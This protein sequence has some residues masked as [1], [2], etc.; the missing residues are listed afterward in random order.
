ITSAARLW[1]P[2]NFTPSRPRNER[3]TATASSGR[4]GWPLASLSLSRRAYLRLLLLLAPRKK[5]LAQA[6]WGDVRGDVLITPWER[7]KSRKQV[8]KKR[9][10]QTPLVPFAK[11]ALDSIAPK[12]EPQPDDPI[13]PGRSGVS[14]W[15]GSQLVRKLVKA[16]A[17]AGFTYHRVRHTVATWLE[18]EGHDEFDRKLVLNHV[19]V[20]GAT[21]GYSHGI[22]LKRKRM[23]LRKWAAH[24]EGLVNGKRV[25]GRAPN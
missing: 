23:L 10:Y 9:A 5:E 6:T 24:V 11:S 20:G 8:T 18:N 16:G 15:P 17:P 14:M 19:A 13:F 4:Y 2:L 25:V 22:A 21:A 7:T 3:P 1:M 12:N